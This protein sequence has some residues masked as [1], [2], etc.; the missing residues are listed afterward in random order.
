MLDTRNNYTGPRFDI[1]GRELPPL[2]KSNSFD[3]EQVYHSDLLNQDFTNAL[4]MADAERK[5]L[6]RRAVPSEEELAIEAAPREEWE[7]YLRGKAMQEYAVET[8]PARQEAGNIFV[9]AHPELKDNKSN[10]DKFTKALQDSGKLHTA[11]D[12]KDLEAIYQTLVARG[13]IELNKTVV[14][15]QESARLAAAAKRH[16]EETTFDAEAAETMPMDELYRRG[17]GGGG[18]R[19]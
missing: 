16:R 7:P 2:E 6:M 18:L 19:R 5:E 8:A 3:A 9:L 13:E 10:A 1:M 17:G 15:K 11:V 4:V 12:V 14:A